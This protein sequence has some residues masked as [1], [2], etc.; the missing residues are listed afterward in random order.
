[1]CIYDLG[2]QARRDGAPTPHTG[3]N[4]NVTITD[5]RPASTVPA[6]NYFPT[7]EIYLLVRLVLHTQFW[8][9]SFFTSRLLSTWLLVIFKERIHEPF[10]WWRTTLLV[11]WAY[12]QIGTIIRQY[13]TYSTIEVGWFCWDYKDW[14]NK[15]GDLYQY[16]KESKITTYLTH[17]Y[18]H[19]LMCF[20]FVLLIYVLDSTNST[21]VRTGNFFPLTLIIDQ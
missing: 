9:P 16:A 10:G 5:P 19:S 3:A 21:H 18:H 4:Q 1:M 6:L 15:L 12:R 13:P 7:R 11:L 8:F 17:L 14:N 2:H 20:H